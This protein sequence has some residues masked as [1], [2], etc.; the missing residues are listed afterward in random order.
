M[1]TAKRVDL[2]LLKQGR[3]WLALIDEVR[4]TSEIA[5]LRE[6][7][8]DVVVILPVAPDQTTPACSPPVQP[9]GRL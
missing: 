5:I 3:A 4:K 2:N 7:G 1:P 9:V 6:G 8:V